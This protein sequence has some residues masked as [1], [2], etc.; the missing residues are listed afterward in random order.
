MAALTQVEFRAE[1]ALA[2]RNMPTSD[3]Y[4]G[5]AAAVIDRFITRGRNEVVRQ[6]IDKGRGRFPELRYDVTIGPTVAGQGRIARPSTFMLIDR[7]TKQGASTVV[8]SWAAVREQPVTFKPESV[9]VFLAKDTAT[10]YAT[11]WTRLG[12]EILYY[13]TT[14][15]SHVDYFHGYGV[16]RETMSASGA[17]FIADE[18]WDD[19]TVLQA[20]AMI[21]ERR[22]WYSHSRELYDRVKDKLKDTAD[23]TALEELG[24]TNEVSVEGAPTRASTYGR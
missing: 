4:Y 20:A 5:A 1:V 18:F 8:T 13:P 15:A 22:G 17:A 11:L 21:Q 14:D 6:A 3:P 19:M 10:G 7:I 12:T 23:I 9:F 2:C 16:R 24:Q